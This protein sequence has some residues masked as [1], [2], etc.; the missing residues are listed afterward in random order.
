MSTLRLIQETIEKSGGEIFVVGG[1]VR[2]FVQ[3]IP[4]KDIDFLVRNLTLEQIATSIKTIGK[5]DEVGK[6]FGVVKGT[7]EGKTFDFAIPRIK[8]VKTG[9]SHT[10]FIIQ[11]DSFATVESDL[12]RRDFTINSLCLPLKDFIKG[13][14]SNVIDPHNGLEDIKNKVLRTVGNP[15]DRFNEDSLR[16]LRGLQFSSRFDLTVHPDT[17]NAMKAL[18]DTLTSVSGERIFD[19]FKKAWAKGSSSK[20]IMLLKET[21]IG[22]TLFG[23]DFKPIEFNHSPFFSYEETIL[24]GIVAFFLNGGDI[25]VL[26]AEMKHHQI[27]TLAK[28]TF[29][30][31]VSP[32]LYAGQKKQMLPLLFY[33]A[34]RFDS[35]TAEKIYKMIH[36]PLHPKE[37]LLGGGEISQ[38]FQVKGIQ[39]GKIQEALLE[40][41]W[42][43]K[44]KNTKED[45]IQYVHSL[46]S[47]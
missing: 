6:S 23:K 17:F 46:E 1:T 18:K 36:M 47:Y 10:D 28:N 25:K 19:E 39:I 35:I 7:I 41:L 22:E 45:L 24:I 32:H 3:R 12:S 38:M 43:G 30:S 27:L 16:I 21:E 14:L 13:N 42:E 37:L 5:A 4:P 15:F 2:D 26:K 34:L 20:F 9:N 33:V 29:F 44:V 31:T 11:T 8:E 40:A